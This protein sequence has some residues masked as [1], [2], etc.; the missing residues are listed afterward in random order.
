MYD[1][2][3]TTEEQ[4]FFIDHVLLPI[5]G[6][7]SIVD[8]QHIIFQNELKE[9]IIDKINHLLDDLLTYF[10]KH[11]FNLHKTN[12]QIQTTKQAFNL[13]QICLKDASIPFSENMTRNKNQRFTS[14]RL[15]HK[16]MIFE[17]Y[18]EQKMTDFQQKT[19]IINMGS[20]EPMTQTG[21]IPKTEL[22]ISE[23]ELYSKIKTRRHVKYILC[24]P[25]TNSMYLSKSWSYIDL[26]QC[27]EQMNIQRN[28]ACSCCGKH[29][30]EFLEE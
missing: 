5:F 25:I 14:L 4:I 2:T 22:T 13:L 17:N 20:T 8:Y 21:S 27:F 10:P 12:H 29:S 26:K 16:N 1:M 3:K 11:L 30:F 6:F 7:D 9:E 15:N 19:N 28:P 24:N 18:I 23:S